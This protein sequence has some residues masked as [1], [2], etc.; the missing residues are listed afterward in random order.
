MMG[1]TGPCGP[2]SE[3]NIDSTERIESKGS[4]VD[5]DSPLC[6]E[7]WNLFFMQFNAQVDGTFAPLDNKHVDTG[8]G[9]ERIAGIVKKGPCLLSERFDRTTS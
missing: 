4:L 5:R 2:C 9:L 7:I 8:M 1:D 6:I 3:I